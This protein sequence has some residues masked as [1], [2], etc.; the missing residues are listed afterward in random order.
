MMKKGYLPV[1]SRLIWKLLIIN[2]LV[3]GFVIIIVWLSIDYLAADYF[4]VLM[5]KYHISPGPSHDMFLGAVHRYLI[6]ASLLALLLAILLSFLLIQRVLKPLSQMTD[7]TRNIA[8]GHYSA[9]IPVTSK[10]EVGQLATA[11]NRMADSLHNIERLRKTMMT[12]V[13]HELRTPLNNMQGYLE[14]LIDGV[15]PKSTETF[16][17]LHEETLRLTHL[18]E[19]ILRLARAE[20]AK[21]NLDPMDIRIGNV[22]E[23]VLDGFRTEFE[24]KGIGVDTKGVDPAVRVYADPDK[25]TQVVQNLMQNAFQYTTFGG[26]VNI[27]TQFT[28]GEIQVVFAN[29]GVEVAEKDL[30]FIFER[31]YRGEQS[32]SREHG[33]AG[34]GLAIVKEL[35]EAHSGKV[36]ATLHDDEIHIWF[37]LPV[38]SVTD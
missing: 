15:V 7:I 1:T 38:F 2:I 33:G 13:A 37:S 29:T 8:S 11:F 34:I 12:D 32:R 9:S 25:L 21:G 10:D 19:D 36:G 17:L 4:M 30:A 6:W 14:A 20:A 22:I 16:E 23:R 5:E 3:I 18:V 24:T 27:F 28:K 35:I 31:F 26:K